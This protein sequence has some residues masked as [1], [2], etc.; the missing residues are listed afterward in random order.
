MSRSSPPP[1]LSYARFTN[2]GSSVRKVEQTPT[3]SGDAPASPCVIT[4]CGQLQPDDPSLEAPAPGTAESGDRY[5]EYP[6]D[7]DSVDISKPEVALQV[8][9][10]HLL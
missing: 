5:Q 9:N 8:S 3:S 1:L 10:G 4:A 6:E 7:E 2:W